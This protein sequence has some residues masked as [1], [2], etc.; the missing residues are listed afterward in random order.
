MARHAGAAHHDGAG[1]VLVAQRTADFDH[2]RQRAFARGGI[3]NAH[4]ERP[5]AGE[6][7]GQA[8]LPEIAHVARDRALRD[9]DDA[10]RFGAGER[11]Q[12]A[13]LG[14]AE[15]RPF[16]AFAADLKAGIAIA[17]DDEGRRAVVAFH[18][19]SQRHR[20]AIDVG[21]ALDAE[22]ALR[23]GLTHQ[24]RPTL[25]TERPQG[26]LQPLRD[27]RVGVRIDDE[28]AWPGHDGLPAKWR[29]FAQSLSRSAS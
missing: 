7:I 4:V 9:G 21:L 18:Q 11:G 12:H 24:F 13:A 19:P 29:S 17:G 10:E 27:C 23:Q 15:Y 8:H 22:R 20:N 25:E 3:G 26:L 16:R 6:A 28:N 14:N 2:L 1:A 5:L